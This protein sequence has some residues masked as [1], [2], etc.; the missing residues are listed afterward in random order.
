MTN[1][2]MTKMHWLAL[3]AGCGMMACSL[4]LGVNSYGVFLTPVAEAL[5]VG[6]A[7]VS[8]HATL[9]GLTTGFLCPPLIQILKKPGKFHLVAGGCIIINILSFI[10][11]AF[12]T[13]L[14]M[15]NILGILRGFGAAGYYV[16]TASMLLSNWFKKNQGTVTGIAV[17]FGGVAGAVFSPLLTNIIT[18]YGYKTAYIVCAVIVAVFSLPATLAISLTPEEKNMHAYGALEQNSTAQAA[19]SASTE[20]KMVNKLSYSSPLF[21]LLMII[22]FVVTLEVGITSHVSGYATSLGI[23]ASVGAAMMSTIMIGNIISKTIFGFIADHISP[24]LTL[25]IMMS[26]SALGLVLILVSSGSVILLIIGGLLFGCIYSITTMGL[27]SLVRRLYGNK[28]YGDAFSMSS[29]AGSMAAAVAITLIGIAYDLTGAYST[30]LLI[31]IAIDALSL[32]L[33]FIACKAGDKNRT[34]EDN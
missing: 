27:V 30:A 10:L 20:K 25:T 8:L 5:G 9:C 3:I 15:F 12:A 32:L 31:G 18:S 24:M 17:S 28:Q 22:S 29:A 11:M 34:F 21:I 33:I 14:W 4:G 13:Q 16:A 1:E 19:A 7:S 23:S 2:K 6:K 26:L